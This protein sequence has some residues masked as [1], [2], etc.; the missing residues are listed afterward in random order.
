M[1]NG[2][3]LAAA[4]DLKW[5]RE[6]SIGEAAGGAA[7]ITGVEV[8]IFTAGDVG[9]CAAPLRWSAAG[10][11]GLWSLTT[12]P[13]CADGSSMLV[14]SCPKCL[15]SAATE[16]E[17]YMHYSC[18][19]LL[20]QAAAKSAD[21]SATSI[22]VDPA[23]TS[24]TAADGPIASVTFAL[25]TMLVVSAETMGGYIVLPASV[26]AVR[27]AWDEATVRRARP[28]PT[29][30]PP[31]PAPSPRSPLRPQFS[32]SSTS[33]LVAV[34][35]PL[36]AQYTAITYSQVTTLQQLVSSLIGLL[37]LIGSFASAMMALENF[38]SDDR[39]ANW[40]KRTFHQFPLHVVEAKSMHLAAKAA[41]AKEG[42]ASPPKSALK[43]HHHNATDAP[44]TLFVS[45]ESGSD[46]A[47]NGSAAAPF[48][49]LPHALADAQANS[50]ELAIRATDASLPANG[51]WRAKPTL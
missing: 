39:I 27:A 35:L 32:P 13:A 3:V 51:D 22:V 9:M 6:I 23:Q 44:P 42:A 50:P 14:F 43:H 40:L 17:V 21:G 33:V 49:T 36:S 29:S 37:A 18:Q 38:A 15:L 46:A 25:Q 26:T 7:A 5:N 34:K 1:L 8:R 4:K 31:A 12:Q 2:V 19:A 20:L 48:A 28:T 41:A 16:L 30:P 10:T 45:P 24:A 47:G 11:T